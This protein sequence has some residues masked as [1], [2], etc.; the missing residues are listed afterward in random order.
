[1]ESRRLANSYDEVTRLLGGTAPPII[2][3]VWEGN[4]RLT[5]RY[6]NPPFDGYVPGLNEHCIV[7]HVGGVSQ[8]WVRIDGKVTTTSMVPGTLSLVP[9]GQDSWRRSSRP[10]EVTNVY[11]GGERLQA[12]ADQVAHGRS[13]E[14][15][16]RVGFTD[17]K[18]L[19]IMTLLGD[20]A[21]SGEPTP[22]LFG[23][24]LIDLLCMQLLRLHSSLAAPLQPFPRRGLAP[25][26]VKRVT[27]YMRENVHQDI[28]VQE[29]A[30]LVGLSRFH[31]CTAFRLATGRTPY[32][33]LTWHRMNRAR[34][35]LADPALRVIDVAL[36][37]GYHTP[38]AFAASFRRAVGVT[39]TEFRRKR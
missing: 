8:S 36:A 19:A 32:E 33:S 22:R 38:S 2:P 27:S 4:T 29:L 21:T 5:G 16:D 12:C 31:F 23:E 17:A 24:H 15:I 14:L 20:E 28:G 39:P 9:R 10:M 7:C 18:L 30:G 35:L 25:W 1:M 26:Q 11:L 6:R 37:V 34:I 13:P 3:N